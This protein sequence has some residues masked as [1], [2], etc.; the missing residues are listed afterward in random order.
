MKLLLSP[1]LTVV[2]LLLLAVSAFAANPP[3]EAFLGTNGI[4]IRSNPPNGKIL[5]DGAFITNGGSAVFVTT[6]LF[7]VNNTY[8]SNLFTTNLF[9]N[10]TLVTSNLFVTNLT[11]QNITVLQT[12]FAIS[13]IFVSNLYATNIVVNNLN[14]TSNLFVTNLF[15]TNI[16]VENISVTSNLFVNNTYATNIF[17]E[18]NIFTT[19]LYATN[20]F[21][22]QDII[23]S[24]FFTINNYSSNITVTNIFVNQTVIT[25]NL[26]V[27]N[28]VA[29]TIIGKDILWTNDNGTVRLIDQTRVG[30]GTNSSDAMWLLEAGTN[31]INA[32]AYSTGGVQRFVINSNGEPSILKGITYSW[33][34][35][36]GAAGTVLTNN[37]SGVLGWGTVASANPLS[38]TTNF[39]NLSVQA[40]KFGATNYPAFNNGYDAWET[41]FYETNAEGF[42]AILGANWQF[43]VPSDYATNSLQLLINYSLINTNGPNT[44]NVIFGASILVGRSGTTN[45]IRTNLFGFTA[46]GTNDWIAK[47]DGTNYVTNLVINLG[48]NAAIKASDLSVIKIQR[49][50]PSDTYGG[51]VSIHGLQL[52]YTRQ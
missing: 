12:L 35:A 28:L 23:T 43:M 25:S 52:I 14:V 45:N 18:Q 22:D 29:N 6:N 48:T 47:Y 31:V 39:M 37:G 13:N 44:S 7:V 17:V 16:F 8:T 50:A 10:Q 40:A 19:N 24:N 49:D 11:V 51:A 3:Y 20:I 33:P 2:C 27:T 1:I 15:S 4:I 5:V 32:F 38:G 36:Q 9:V 46:W 41:T 34:T 42:R 26:F 30:V 21:V